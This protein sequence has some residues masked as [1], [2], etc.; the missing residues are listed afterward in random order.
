[1]VPGDVTMATLGRYRLYVTFANSA[2]TATSS[3]GQDGAEIKALLIRALRKAGNAS[4]KIDS[5]LKRATQYIFP[6]RWFLEA[7]GL[8]KET[9]PTSV[10]CVIEY[11][12]AEAARA[13]NETL[14][15][16]ATPI[17]RFGADLQ[18]GAAQ[19][20]CPGEGGQGLFA[21]RS[22]AETLMRSDFLAQRG[23]RGRDVNVIVVDQGFDETLVP[24][25]GGRWWN[26]PYQPPK[27]GSEHGNRVVRNILTLAPEA[28]FYDLPLIPPAITDVPQFVSDAHKAFETVR[29]DIG[30]LRALR[31]VTGPW[32]MANAW[33]VF[34]RSSEVPLGSYTTGRLHPFNKEVEE[35]EKAG[36][37]LVFA[38]GNCG[39]FCPD[40]RCS[41]AGPG[42]SIWGANAHP[43]VL[44]VGA[45]RADT[46]WT[47]YS[48]QGPGPA[49]L[50]RDKPDLCAPSQ[51]SENDDARRGN[52]GTSTACALAAG[53][54]AAM[55]SRWDTGTVPPADLRNL[56]R[57]TARPVAPPHDYRF[58]F[59][60]LDVRNA[61]QSAEAQYS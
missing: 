6:R 49:S 23:L 55:R 37:D 51:F 45:V 25:F 22:A 28:T 1:M 34:D 4:S 47:G 15:G 16:I 35:V 26:K 8:P 21:T 13:L 19:Y 24:R 39:Q 60:V 52:T 42:H 61:V 33:A 46:M 59:G 53:A 20:W 29:H 36:V 2:I 17:F 44:T 11:E 57:S 30:R 14:V 27:G 12:D 58:G 18:F 9:N 3:G 38:A 31:G 40:R 5:L 32:V 41:E 48:S 43:Q 56:L 54:I 7:Y 10:I 50:Q